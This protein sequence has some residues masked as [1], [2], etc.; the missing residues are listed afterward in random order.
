MPDGST[1]T[2]FDRAT[3]VVPMGRGFTHEVTVD[4]EWAIGTKPHGG[5]LLALLARA[6]IDA[7][8]HVEGLAHPHPMAVSAHYLSAPSPGRAEARSEVIRRGRRASHVRTRLVQDGRPRVEAMFT[9]GRLEP[10]TEPW[11][12]RDS[13]PVATAE[14]NCPPRSAEGPNGMD[15]PIMRHVAVRFDPVT[16]GFHQGQPTGRGEI[17]GWFR[18]T[19]GR[20]P[21][22]L[23][24]LLAVDILPPATFDLGTSGWVP[25][26]ELTAYVR[27]LPAPGPL[28]VEHR[29]RLVEA[30]MVDEACCVWDAAG[31]LVA[32]ATQLAAVRME[33]GPVPVQAPAQEAGDQAT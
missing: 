24:L 9:L 23:A 28:L 18:F 30:D 5:Y 1:D 2:A 3:A 6:A 25:T 8:S 13:R 20:P 4:A 31:R 15:L 27:G 14:E 12:Q 32:Q 33:S 10:G 29:A 19:D 22:P 17:R 26:L 7:M 11:W 16:A 21:D